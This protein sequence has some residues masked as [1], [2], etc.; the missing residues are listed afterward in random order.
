[1]NPYGGGISAS[2]VSLLRGKV[3][4]KWGKVDCREWSQGEI[5]GGCVKCR[6][7]TAAGDVS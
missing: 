4:S 2:F 6:W 5:L 3:V 1:M 7:C